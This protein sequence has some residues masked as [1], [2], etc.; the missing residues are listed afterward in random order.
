MWKYA[1]ICGT[2]A[3]ICEARPINH[4]SY[5]ATGLGKIPPFSSSPPNLKAVELG[6]I[7]NFPPIYVRSHGTRSNKRLSNTRLHVLLT[8]KS[9]K[10]VCNSDITREIIKIFQNK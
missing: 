7:L 1:E 4:V 6:K 5:K 3:K 8:Q 10:F 2:H 9:E